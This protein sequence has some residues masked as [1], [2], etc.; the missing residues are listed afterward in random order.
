MSETKFEDLLALAQ[1][2]TLHGWDFSWLNARSDESPL[3]WDYRTLVKDHMAGIA[4]M[5]DLGTGGGE[6]L[7]ALA[8][9]PPRTYA[10]E[11]YP[12][13]VVIARQR[14]ELFGVE[15]FDMNQTEGRI[16]LPDHSIDLA[17]DR[18][19]GGQYQ[20]AFR[21]LKPGG[22]LVTQQVGGENMMDLNRML[23][24]KP[25]FEFS[26]V[27]LEYE[28]GQVKAAGFTIL[29]AREAFPTQTFYDIASV[30]FYLNAVPWQIEDFTVD[31]YRDRL[32]ALHQR[33]EREGKIA[34]REHRELILARKPLLT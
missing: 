16:P 21:V 8:P 10:T 12:P 34:F 31:R 3:P 19:E 9:L 7:A 17:I 14:L 1:Q 20:E 32:L 25:S 28:V 27:S 2:Q 15:V 18:H 23:Q 30:V 24:D 26:Y 13:N 29:E 22:H 6:F 33:F 4:S 11:G 5:V